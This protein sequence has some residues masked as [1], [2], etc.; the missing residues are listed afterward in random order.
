MHR[1]RTIEMTEHLLSHPS[2]FAGA[3]SCGR[4]SGKMIVKSS[5]GIARSFH[6]KE[7]MLLQ[8]DQF[9]VGLA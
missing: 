2:F 3:P 1:K 7:Q 5:L 4:T 8:H 6:R 9:D